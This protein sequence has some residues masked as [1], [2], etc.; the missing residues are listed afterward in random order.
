MLQDGI[1]SFCW[2]VWDESLIIFLRVRSCYDIKRWHM[3]T[4]LTILSAK[5][6]AYI[7]R[8]KLERLL[9]HEV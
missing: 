4:M 6:I 9:N 1:L 3:D 8:F 7:F 5:F 2:Q